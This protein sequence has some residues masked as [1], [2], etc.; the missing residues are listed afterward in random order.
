MLDGYGTPGAWEGV[1][2][3]SAA[4]GTEGV[5]GEEACVVPV[6][7]AACAG[8]VGCAPCECTARGNAHK[9]AS[10]G[11]KVRCFFKESSGFLVR[12]PP[13]RGRFP[14]A[15]RRSARCTPTDTSPSTRARVIA[16]SVLQ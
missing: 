1:P 2:L 8:P 3:H 4:S 16:A 7:C 9:V 14:L 13:C 12:L 10:T 6:G 5:E 15:C 11:R